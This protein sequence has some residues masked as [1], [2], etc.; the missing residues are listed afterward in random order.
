MQTEAA[1][2]AVA[3]IDGTSEVEESGD[4][5]QQEPD[6]TEERQE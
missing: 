6:E 3:L 1:H 2:L 5:D 4:D